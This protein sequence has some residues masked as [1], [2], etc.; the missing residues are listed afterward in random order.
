MADTSFLGAAVRAAVGG[1]NGIAVV[2]RGRGSTSCWQVLLRTASV[3][4]QMEMDG[5]TWK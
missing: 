2:G 5:L 4:G 1:G 3:A